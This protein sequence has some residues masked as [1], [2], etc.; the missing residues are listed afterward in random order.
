[1]NITTHNDS[2][3]NGEVNTNFHFIGITVYAGK[4]TILSMK[5]Q[6]LVNLM[7]KTT[8]ICVEQYIQQCRII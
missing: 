6:Q 1:V 8:I 7:W 5:H 3:H 4:K 2:K